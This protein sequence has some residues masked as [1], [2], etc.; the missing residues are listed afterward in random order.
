[1]SFVDSIMAW[2]GALPFWAVIVL[3]A[4]V[5]FGKY[6]FP[7]VPTDIVSVI[8]A[9]LAGKAG[10]PLAPLIAAYLF[11]SLVGIASAHRIGVWLSGVETWPKLIERFR[12]PLDKIV[13]QFRERGP[14]LVVTNRFIP[15]VRD[16]AIVA[17]GLAGMTWQRT[18]VL[19][20]ISSTLWVAVVFGIGA[21]AGQNWELVMERLTKLG[22]ATWILFAVAIVTLVVGRWWQKRSRTAVEP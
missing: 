21:T 7:P 15:V 1:M 22:T 19:G 13:D 4:S 5:V 12:P 18:L 10:W 6:V 17:A 14:R 9:F 16:F 2:I 20:M 11:G 3:V 8:A